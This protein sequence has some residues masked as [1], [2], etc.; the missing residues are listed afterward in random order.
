MKIFH[1]I[2]EIREYVLRQK[3]LGKTIGF[4]PTMGALHRGHERLVECSVK[5]NDTTI[6]SIFVNPTQFNNPHDLQN[7]PRDLASDVELLTQAGCDAV[8]APDISDMYQTPTHVRM[9][10]GMLESTMEGRFRPGHFSGVGVVVAKLFNIISPIKAYFGKKDLQ[11]LAVIQSLVRDLNFNI[12]I[13]PV[14]TVRETGGL[15]MSSR[16]RLLTEEE[17]TIA[18]N[19]NTS[20]LLAKE[21]LLKGLSPAEVK[22]YIQKHFEGRRYKT[23][24]FRNR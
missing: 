11:Q 21:N 5:E 8:F 2:Q 18:L 14:D 22:S 24:V 7:Y 9:D 13:V 23:G 16:N 4:V 3:L 15:A 6:C 20:L 19:L 12:E 1:G 17:R 10:F